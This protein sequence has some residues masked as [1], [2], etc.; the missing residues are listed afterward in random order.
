MLMDDIRRIDTILKSPS[1]KRKDK[2]MGNTARHGITL[3]EIVLILNLIATVFL[4]TWVYKISAEQDRRAIFARIFE[5]NL[6][7]KTR[8]IK[9]DYLG[10]PRR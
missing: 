1:D 7:E 2:A 5:E 10:K 4:A 8:N 3:L 6:M 9:P